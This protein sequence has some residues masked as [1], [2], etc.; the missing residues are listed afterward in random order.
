VSD[1]EE[2]HDASVVLRWRERITPILDDLWALNL[3][4]VRVQ[5]W[6]VV[7]TH[8]GRH[9]EADEA[10]RTALAVQHLGAGQIYAIC[11]DGPGVCNYFILLPTSAGLTAFDRQGAGRNFLL[12]SEDLSYVILCTSEDYNLYAGPQG[13][14][15][16]CLGTDV[17]TA[18]QRFREGATDP[19][20][21]YSALRSGMNRSRNRCRAA[22]G[23]S[24]ESQRSLRRWEG[25]V[26]ASGH[27][28]MR[29][30]GRK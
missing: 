14:V 28:S 1:I 18:R 5:R 20:G 27:K 19:W 11:T 25:V 10:A 6:T 2:I 16:E 21:C 4:W 17:Q 30:S 9:F 23:S 8:R 13:F 22:P 26:W 29:I 3:D 24:A 12:T 15:E 7:P